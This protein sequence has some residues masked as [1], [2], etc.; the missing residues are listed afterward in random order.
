ML[1]APSAPTPASDKSTLIL[2]K[3]KIKWFDGHSI[4]QPKIQQLD[5]TP[6]IIFSGEFSPK[7]AAT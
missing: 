1:V 5:Q 7:E 4:S 2:P 6:N 3:T